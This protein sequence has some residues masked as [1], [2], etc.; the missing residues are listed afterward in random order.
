V[1]AVDDRTL[2]PNQPPPPPAV[3]F[4]RVR[5]EESARGRILA[6]IELHVRERKAGNDAAARRALE[7][8]RASDAATL[9]TELA[10]RAF[11]A[12]KGTPEQTYAR[13]LEIAQALGRV[14]A[15]VPERVGVW[16]LL[17]AML[18]Q[19][20]RF[21]GA[22]RATASGLKRAPADLD[23]WLRRARLQVKLGELSAAAKSLRECARLGPGEPRVERMLREHPACSACGALFAH[24]R[25]MACAVCRAPGPGA[26]GRV[27]TV[28]RQSSS[29][30]DLFFVQVREVIAQALGMS[31]EAAADTITLNTLLK[32]HVGCTPHECGEV[33]AAMAEAFP[34]R[35]EPEMFRPAVLGYLDLLV[36]DLIR[37]IQPERP[38]A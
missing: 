8:A 24:G 10:R 36:A 17:A 5:A 26:G 11:L 25:A 13:R 35:F 38:Q 21:D 27:T 4:A 33:L 23:L 28:R 19:L 2:F 9:E 3:E 31:P 12:A 34:G 37:A 16:R 6:L 15:A 30:F 22:L 1:V 29:K 20:E 14:A 18:E 32:A 7:V